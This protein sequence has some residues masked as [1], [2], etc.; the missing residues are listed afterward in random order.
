MLCGYIHDVF[1][2]NIISPFYSQ[3]FL[4]QQT[5]VSH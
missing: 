2:K 1:Q 5:K 4:P 3:L